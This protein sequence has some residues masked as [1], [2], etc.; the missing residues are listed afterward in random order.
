LK[1]KNSDNFVT[2]LRLL[3]AIIQTVKKKLITA[4]KNAIW[5]HRKNHR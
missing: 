3:N 1:H 5:K 2:G 4:Q